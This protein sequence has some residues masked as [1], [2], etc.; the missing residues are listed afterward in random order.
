MKTLA[1]TL[2]ALL[3]FLLSTAYPV[4]AETCCTPEPCCPVGACHCHLAPSTTAS[5]TTETPATLPALTD[6]LPLVPATSPTI[7]LPPLSTHH[8]PSAVAANFAAPPLYALTHAL[9]I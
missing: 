5:P 6:A 2:T 1:Q 4:A 3:A 7:P 9:L 8:A